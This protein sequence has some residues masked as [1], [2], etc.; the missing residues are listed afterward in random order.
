MGKRKGLGKADI[1]PILDELKEGLQ[2]IYGARLRQVIL[3]GSYARG[4][5]EPGS[6]IDVAVVLD[7]YAR[8][9]EEARRIED[10]WGPL[11]LDSDVLIQ[12]FFVRERDVEAPWRPVHVN[13]HREGVQA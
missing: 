13:L 11:C 5:A 4:E 8:A 6:D 10:V 12:P 2:A 7:D 3:F 1:Q 9:S